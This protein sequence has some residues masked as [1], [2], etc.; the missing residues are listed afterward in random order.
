M[1]Q[2]S[3]AGFHFDAEIGLRRSPRQIRAL[4]KGET[5]DLEEIQ[6]EDTLGITEGSDQG[7]KPRADIDNLEKPELIDAPEKIVFFQTMLEQL[8]ANYGWDIETHTGDVPRKRC[9]SAHLVGGRPRKYTHAV[10]QRDDTTV[11]HI[12]E[13]ELTADE[14]LS[15]LF[16]RA[17]HPQNVLEKIL[18]AL[19][20]NDTSQKLKAM[21]W[22]RKSNA[23]HTI[24]RHYLDHPD[25]KIKSEAEALESWVARAADKILSL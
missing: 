23:E 2:I 11:V 13:I 5:P 8:E 3:Q 15:T 22:K 18:D 17:T 19:M 7:S 4:P 6:E 24:S 21:H 14:S 20:T 1:L 9:R 16:F 10:V 12:F 25:K